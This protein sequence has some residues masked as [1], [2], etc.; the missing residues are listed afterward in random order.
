[1]QLQLIYDEIAEKKM[2]QKKAL[3]DFK[4]ALKSNNSYQTLLGDIQELVSKKK[5]VEM[6]VAEKVG[7]VDE[8]LED[9]K[10]ELKSKSE[11]LSDVAIRDLMDG[12]TV[13]VER[14]G[15]KYIPVWSVKFVKVK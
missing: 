2:E 15:I 3:R 7:L 9:I 14:D 5:S 8:K 12:K 13:E 4:D 6:A 1:M 10:Q 11:M